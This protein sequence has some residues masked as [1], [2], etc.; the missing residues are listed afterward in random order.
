M[1]P[2][3]ISLVSK[4]ECMD[5]GLLTRVEDITVTL[6]GTLTVCAVEF[7]I[8][9]ML[10]EYHISSSSSSRLYVNECRD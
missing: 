4:L 8:G 9:C 5:A 3:R 7:K 10:D 1:W 2:L 6:N